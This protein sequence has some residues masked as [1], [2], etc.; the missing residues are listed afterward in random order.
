MLKKDIRIRNSWG[1]IW[2]FAKKLRAS[3]Q[4]YTF[5]YKKKRVPHGLHGITAQGCREESSRACSEAMRTL[6]DD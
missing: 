1:S 4:I 6:T 5:L 2:A 3:T